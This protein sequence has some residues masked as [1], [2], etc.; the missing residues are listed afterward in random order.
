VREIKSHFPTKNV[1]SPK[2]AKMRLR[3]RVR[4]RPHWGS[5]RRSHTLFSRLGRGHPLPTWLLVP[6]TPSVCL[7]CGV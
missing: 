3:P 1:V 5:W 4:P 2:Y 6:H 7:R